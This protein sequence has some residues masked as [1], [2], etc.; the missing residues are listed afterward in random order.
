MSNF[1]IPT[2]TGVNNVT[3][4]PAPQ[5]NNG[6]PTSL[7]TDQTNPATGVGNAP[8]NG[9]QSAATQG[10]NQASATDTTADQA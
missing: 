3:A 7:A 1:S 10:L 6:T 9:N 2:A 8:L 5:T 4:A